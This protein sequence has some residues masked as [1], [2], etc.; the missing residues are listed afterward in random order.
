[1][2]TSVTANQAV[3]LLKQ[4]YEPLNVCNFRRA[5]VLLLKGKAEALENGRGEIRT[6]STLFTLPSVI[7]LGYMIKRPLLMR[8]DVP[9]RGLHPGQLL[10]PVLRKRDEGNDP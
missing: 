10:V 8:Q 7:R 6:P 5:V 3:L 1:M 9:P 4:N 2:N